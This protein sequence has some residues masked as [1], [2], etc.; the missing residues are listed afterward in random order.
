MSHHVRSSLDLERKYTKT[1]GNAE[2]TNPITL[3]INCNRVLGVSLRDYLF[4]SACITIYIYFLL[5]GRNI[6]PTH[7][8]LGEYWAYY[9]WQV[10]F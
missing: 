1:L 2:T 4:V 9:S 6:I 5:Y 8:E 7:S 3:R 10:L